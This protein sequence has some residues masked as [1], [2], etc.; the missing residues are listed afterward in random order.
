MSNLNPL[1]LL[2]VVL[3]DW[4]SDR[5]RRLVHGVV[6]L[7]MFL[8]TVWLGV[9]GDWKEALLTLAAAIY[10]GANRANTA[11]PQEHD[12]EA[13]VLPIVFQDEAQPE[14]EYEE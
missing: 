6:L 13:M 8:V 9:E 14:L 2:D 11:N 10:A 3:A 12:P 1:A 7:A 5:V 4:A